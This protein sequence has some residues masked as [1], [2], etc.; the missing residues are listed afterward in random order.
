MCRWAVEKFPARTP[1]PVKLFQEA[2]AKDF[3]FFK[4][5]KRE[6]IDAVGE[7]MHCS[8]FAHPSGHHLSAFYVKANTFQDGKVHVQMNGGYI[9]NNDFS[10]E[11]TNP[12]HNPSTALSI[13]AHR[14]TGACGTS[15]CKIPRVDDELYCEY[16]LAA[17]RQGEAER[18]MEVCP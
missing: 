11:E 8:S 4:M 6:R 10:R 3:I 18:S 2:V 12:V 1:L 16:H 7:K 9:S 13:S 14:A 15:L 5:Y 17:K